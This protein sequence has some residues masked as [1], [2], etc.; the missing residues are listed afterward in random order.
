MLMRRATNALGDHGKDRR[1]VAHA[2]RSTFEATG[3]ADAEPMYLPDGADAIAGMH[4]ALDT[5]DAYV[6][7]AINTS[8]F[9]TEWLEAELY[10]RFSGEPPVLGVSLMG[11]AQVFAAL[12]VFKLTKQRWPTTLTVLGGSHATL[13]SREI[14]KDPRYRSDIDFVL[15]GHTED[16]FVDM[17]ARLR[18]IGD[19]PAPGRSKPP[20]EYL[21]RFSREQLLLYD[22]SKITLPLQFTRGCAYARCTFCTY[23]VVEPILTPF[24][25]DGATAAITKL[26]EQYGIR[27]FSIKDSLFTGPMMDALADSLLANAAQIEW[28]MTTKVTTSLAHRASKL[29]QAGLKTVELGV[30][31]IHRHTQAL[32]DKRADRAIIENV[33]L[34]LAEANITV[35][36]NLIFGAPGETIQDAQRQLD[37]F[38]AL[39]SQAPSRIDCSLNLLEIVRGSPLEISPPAGTQLQGIAPWAYS[40]QWNA[41][42]WRREFAQ[43]L[44]A[45]QLL[46]VGD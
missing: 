32:F 27:R 45:V 10:S 38:I 11:P 46:E 20:F 19:V 25:V 41:P 9:W 26:V 34:A 36:V 22:P 17:L 3:L 29:G 28:S 37:W 30:E 18:E 2:A 4:F 31:S 21:P 16:E 8:T 35:I 40:Y 23:P 15:P 33:I 42:P 43:N 14:A 5:L 12:V 7:R 1:L 24:D 13:L 44:Q 6:G 39:R